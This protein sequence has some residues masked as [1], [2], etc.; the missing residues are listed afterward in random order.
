MEADAC[1]HEAVASSTNS[2]DVFKFLNKIL[3]P[4]NVGNLHW[5]AAMVLMTEKR[6]QL[7]DPKPSMGGKMPTRNNVLT[8]NCVSSG[9]NISTK[10]GGRHWW[11]LKHQVGVQFCKTHNFLGNP[12]DAT[13]ESLFLH[14]SVFL[15]SIILSVAAP[16]SD[17]PWVLTTGFSK[18]MG[19]NDLN[20]KPADWLAPITQRTPRHPDMSVL[21]T[22]VL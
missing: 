3:I 9:M 14:S 2:V 4:I 17:R 13:A 1:S 16:K 19:P 18:I 7:C 5:I 15:C 11:C 21:H 10:R 20:V 22:F 8:K 6:M 12:M